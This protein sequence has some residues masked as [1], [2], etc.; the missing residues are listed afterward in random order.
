M[1]SLM[2]GRPFA[3]DEADYRFV[4]EQGFTANYMDRPAQ[5]FGEFLRVGLSQGPEPGKRAA[6]S[7]QVRES[8]DINFY[9]HFHGPLYFYWLAMLNGTSERASR[10]IFM[11]FPIL[12]ILVLFVGPVWLCG[13]TR[14]YVA[15]ALAA[16]TFA[17]GV[18]A[19]FTNELAPHQLFALTTLVVLFLLAKA[20]GNGSRSCW[21]GATLATAVA[22]ATLEV[23]FVLLFTLLVCGFLARERLLADARFM[24]RSAIL[25]VVSVAVLWPGAL[26]RLAFL[27]A[28]LFMAYLAVFRKDAWP[29]TLAESWRAR[30]SMMPI[31]C[32]LIGAAIALWLS[33][34]GLRDR[35]MIPFILFG[36]LTLFSMSP[37]T[38]ITPRYVLPF[39][40]ALVA[41]A[42]LVLSTWL[43]GWKL[44][45]GLKFA[46][47]AAACLVLGANT[48]RVASAQLADGSDPRPG[49]LLEQIRTLHLEGKRLLVPRGDVPLLHYYFPQARLTSDDDMQPGDLP[50]VVD[51][52]V[53]DGYPV[54]IAVRKDIRQEQPLA[55]PRYRGTSLPGASVENRTE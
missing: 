20:M 6:L 4:A 3:Y 54:N 22:F 11:A 25:F 34:R 35:R 37:V 43:D 48:I 41:F 40:P 30:L 44:R 9:R 10:T 32:L 26:L 45:A 15:G 14:G 29:P 51:G 39:L 5:S 53:H 47:V 55:A 31:E 1:S 8:G 17:W 28:Y 46:L 36:L 21:Y 49:A 33:L 52:V 24:Q 23:A 18:P 13:W 2:H 50:V 27:K 7:R 42:A 38:T 12:T 16:G 19:T